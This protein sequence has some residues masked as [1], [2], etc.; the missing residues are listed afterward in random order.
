MLETIKLL[1]NTLVQLLQPLVEISIFESDKDTPM[2]VYHRFGTEIPTPL[3]TQVP[4]FVQTKEG[5]KLKTMSF[6]FED[7][8]KNYIVQFRADVSIFEQLHQQLSLLVQQP[9]ISDSKGT[10]QQQITD[11]THHYLSKH[12]CSLTSLTRHQKRQLVFQLKQQ[13]LLDYKEAT[14]YVATLL[15]LSRATIYNYLQSAELITHL[16]IHQVNSFSDK[17]YGG[18]PAGVVL[19]ASH[20]DTAHMQSIARELN[21]SETAFLI[22]SDKADFQLRYFSREGI[23]VDFCGH[24][25]VGTLHMLAKEKHYEMKSAGEY[26]YKIQT[27]AGIINARIQID[28]KNKISVAYET[29]RVNLVADKMTHEAIGDGCG[30]LIDHINT[31]IPIMKEKTNRSLFITINSLKDLEMIQCDYRR[32]KA[33]MK[34]N[35]L[36]SCC[37][38]TPQTVDKRNDIHMRCFSPI[39][40]VNEDPFTGSVLGGL[41]AYLHKNK[42]IAEDKK[43]FNVEQ[44]H[45]IK[46]PGEVTVKFDFHQGKYDVEVYATARHFCSTEIELINKEQETHY[47]SI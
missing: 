46:R 5:R 40:G 38:L 25:T 7:T 22:S 1:S 39:V 34:K 14:S 30:I 43:S 9:A 26:K 42:L 19:D 21:Y 31:M 4:L 27:K 36:I 15:N 10:W 17:P 12:H 20:L 35:D 16:T 6:P 24:S 37:L 13:G 29:P 23:E 3:V 45:F 8:D 11:F 33:F 41:A 28:Q 47:E 2:A 18:N 44:G 32:M